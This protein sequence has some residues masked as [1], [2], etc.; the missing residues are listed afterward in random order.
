[1]V[2]LAHTER[3]LREP[4]AAAK[5][6]ANALEAATWFLPLVKSASAKTLDDLR[7]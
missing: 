4:E 7:E 6:I 3:A 2:K 5:A 1:M